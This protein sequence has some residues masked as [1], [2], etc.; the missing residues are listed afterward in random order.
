ME[1]DRMPQ[2]EGPVPRTDDNASLVALLNATWFGANLPPETQV[3]LAGLAR[4][5]QAPAGTTLLAEGQL[6][7]ELGIVL[8]GRVSLRT[9]VP[10]EGWITILTVE[11]G[12]IFGQSALVAPYRSTSTV[13]AL[14]AVDVLALDGPGLRAALKVDHDLAAELYPRVLQAMARRL[15][16]TRLQMLDL[17]AK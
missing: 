8:T 14:Q 1:D 15:N 13:V 10:E 5:Y 4:R 16:A 9:L 6:A 3:R 7:N 12:D 17:F 11:P 2:T